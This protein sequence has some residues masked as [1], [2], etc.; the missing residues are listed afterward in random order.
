M[1]C[2]PE[3][4]TSMFAIRSIRADSWGLPSLILV[5]PSWQVV[6]VWAILFLSLW[7]LML[8]EERELLMRFGEKYRAYCI[9]TKRIILLSIL[10]SFKKLSTSQMAG[11]GFFDSLVNC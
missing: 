2:F 11:Q 8:V 7:A 1:G 4:R 3:Y 6:V 10:P 9:Q 5:A